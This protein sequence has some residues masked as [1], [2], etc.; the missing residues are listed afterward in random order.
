MRLSELLFETRRAV[1]G[2]VELASH[3]LI[4]RAGLARQV[5]SGI[6]TLTPIAVRALRRLEAIV[7]DEMEDIGGQEVLLPVVN[8][9]ELWEASDRYQSVDETLVRFTDRTAHDMVLAM[10]HEEAATDLVKGFLKSRRQLPLL[11]FQIQTKFRDELRPRG[12]LVRLREF[13]MKDAYSFHATPEDLD[14][15]YDRVRAAYHRIYARAGVPVVSVASDTGLMGGD[16][17][18][19]F[20]LLTPGGED[21]LV[22]CR[23]CGYAANREVARARVPLPSTLL[24]CPPR[25]HQQATP[26]ALTID[27]LRSGYGYAPDTIVKSVYRLTDQGR[28]VVAL[29]RG[30]QEVNELKL[31]RAAGASLRPLTE[32]AA[33]ARGLNP[34]YV[35]PNP[36]LPPETLV[37]ADPSVTNGGA[38]VTGS[39][40]S[41]VHRIGAVWGRDFSADVTDDV[42]LVREGDACIQCAGNLKLVR[43][44]EV[45][46]IFKLGTRYSAR[47]GLVVQGTGSE[48][49]T[50]WMGC[51][52]IGI[53][54]L[55]AAVLEANHDQDGII[56]PDEAAPWPVQLLTTNTDPDITNAA[57]AVYQTLGPDRVLY[58]DR[59][60][61]PGAKFYDADLL[62]MPWRITVSPRSLDRGGVE[63][64]RRRDGMTRI[65]RPEELNAWAAEVL[66]R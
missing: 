9:R 12:G 56:W 26:D 58:D 20:M 59:P 37:V 11:I 15:L 17:A 36:G 18:H 23:S 30:D 31:G 27:D 64:R 3:Q 42:A 48:A 32:D 44:I 40:H 7:R 47:M 43:G 19:E 28:V 39:N 54:R 21:T 34:G 24:P 52:G 51:Y 29:I 61:S 8:P 33:R 46:N 55:L 14:A 22:L 53:T 38:F 65:V 57:D 13:L 35:G 25:V 2:D 10:T 4:L 62:G 1:S 66:P 49:L 6:Y 5:A 45:G 41:G 50:P 16:A 63:M 60:Q